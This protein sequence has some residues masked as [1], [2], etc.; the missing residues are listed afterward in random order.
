[1]KYLI[2]DYSKRISVCKK[3]YAKVIC[4]GETFLDELIRDIKDSVESTS[5]P[6]SDRSNVYDKH[7]I[8]LIMKTAGRLGIDITP[9]KLGTMQVHNS[10]KMLHL[11]SWFKEYFDVCG[12]CMPNRNGEIHLEPVV[13]IAVYDEYLLDTKNENQRASVVLLI[14]RMLE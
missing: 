6:F 9:E 13:K 10:D 2:G 4:R 1:M 3:V 14:S 7:E 12:D 8:A 5:R 11:C